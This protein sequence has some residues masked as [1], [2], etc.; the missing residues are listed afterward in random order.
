MVIPAQQG[1]P[2]LATGSAGG[3]EQTVSAG[4][5][6]RSDLVLDYSLFGDPGRPVVLFL[7]GITGSRNYFLKKVRRLTRHY[8]LLLPDLPGFG[9]SAKPRTAYTMD[10]YRD[11]VRNTVEAAGCQHEPIHIV[12]HSL[13]ATIAL[14]YAVRYSE[15]VD[16]IVC[17]G[18]VRFQNSR[19]A[20]DLFWKGSPN[21]RR[22]LN[23]HSMA[24]NLSQWKRTGL[25]MMAQYLVRFPLSVIRDSRKFTFNSLTSTLENCLLNYRV[26]TVLEK[27]QPRPVLLL[28]GRGDQVAPFDHIKELPATYPY[29][30]LV[31]IPRS[32]HH[33]FLTHTK[34]CMRLIEEHLRGASSALPDLAGAGPGPVTEPS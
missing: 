3:S 18:L 28:H 19:M 33:I 26:D 5:S 25:A 24:E 17:M 29:M 9:E 1:E 2:D 15:H 12:G 13:G 6:E 31:A 16:R 27:L 4:K 8:R 11:T 10:F 7:H 20:H 22:L 32:G 34:S 14:E 21:Y 23:E 30:E